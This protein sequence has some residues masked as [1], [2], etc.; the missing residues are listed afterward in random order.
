MQNHQ[1]QLAAILFTDIVGYTAM[2]QQNE[3]TAV[4]T[5]NRYITVLQKCISTHGGKILNDYG[6]GSLCSFSSATQAVKCAVDIQNQLREEPTVPLRIGLHVGEIFFENE[7]VLGD[8]VNVASR[9]QSLGQANSILFS[10][11]ICDKI[12]NQPEF[13]SVSLG[14]FEFKNV[15]GPVEVLALANDGLF[16]PK[17]KNIEGKLKKKNSLKKKLIIA[18]TALILI[19]ASVFIYK[20]IGGNNFLDK[21]KSIAILPFEI[22]GN[23]DDN[24]A[25]GLVEDILV[26]LSKIKELSKVI[27]NKSSSQYR[28]TRK[29]LKEIGED[30][31]AVFLVTGSV[32]EIGSTIRVSAQLIDSKN[33]N[34]IWADDYTRENKQIFDLQTELATQI[35]GALKTKITPEEKI[36]LSKRYTD[37][38][39]AYSLYRKGRYFW[40]TRTKSSFDSAEA[41]YKKAIALDPD[42]ALAYAGLADCYTYNQKGLTQMEAIPIGRDYATKALSLD[43]NLSEAF[44]TMGLIQ[45]VF[46]YDWKSAKKTLEKAIDLNPNYSFAHLYYGNLL[47]YTGESAEQGIKEN[48][49]ALELDPL[50][51]QL[52]WVLGRNYWLD[53][54]YDSS[55][56]QIKK[57]LALDQTNGL[58]K[59]T[60]ALVLLA[61]KNYSEAFQLIKQFP[62]SV[63]SKTADYQAPYLSYAYALTGDT[64]QAKKILENILIEHPDQNQYFLIRIYI[65]LKDFDGAI[66]QFE[67]CYNERALA[68]YFVKVDPTFDPIH[69][70]PRFKALLKKMNLE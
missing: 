1:R 49:K 31:D 36:G 45:S 63:L 34:T 68:M 65:A 12:R 57:T 14:K 55:Y 33:G 35:V 28:N 4:A 70:D 39:E 53:H 56:E 40:D 21:E 37:N 27:S 13:K 69:N 66:R 8:G 20:R 44:T 64:L 62:V 67:K 11:E 5:L 24:L 52:N 7:K 26:R 32:Q 9:I 30:L 6:D 10:K 23:N 61:K 2:M 51:V 38:V 47:Q 48:K 58:A 15:D 18:A 3:A 41:Y 17:R 19:I 25:A 60:L 42:Y 46:D 16:V 29:T 54:K 43:S 59:G 22:I 50:S